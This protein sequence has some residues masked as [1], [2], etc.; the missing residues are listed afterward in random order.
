MTDIQSRLA[1]R[2]RDLRNEIE[3]LERASKA[4]G[5][6]GSQPRRRGRSRQ[7]TQSRSRSRGGR[8]RQTRMDSREREAQ[9]LH[10]IREH[11]QEGVSVTDLAAEVGVSRSY[12]ASTILPPLDGEITRT[13]GRV[14]AK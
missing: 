5:S 4:L 7:T 6:A 1:D 8:R 12:L 3:R 2:L 14:S 13:R 11:G 9:V 10:R